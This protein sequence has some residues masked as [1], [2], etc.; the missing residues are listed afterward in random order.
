MAEP[1]ITGLENEPETHNTLVT[2]CRDHRAFANASKKDK[3]AET[4]SSVAF[5]VTI[6][7]NDG[8]QREKLAKNCARNLLASYA[9]ALGLPLRDYHA[10]YL[11]CVFFTRAS[12]EQ[13]LSFE[14]LSPITPTA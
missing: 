12:L 6:A 13:G 11:F 8:S 4:R 2:D 3:Q 1:G 7:C 14:Q 10:N 9:A 5:C